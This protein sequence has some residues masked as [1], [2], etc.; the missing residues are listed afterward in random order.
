VLAKAEGSRNVRGALLRVGGK[1]SHLIGD[2][3]AVEILMRGKLHVS[4]E[5]VERNERKDAK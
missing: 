2:A 3:V 5:A 4:L 1:G